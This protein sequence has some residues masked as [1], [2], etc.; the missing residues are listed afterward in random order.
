MRET[1]ELA[2][3]RR[4][5]VAAGHPQT[6]GAAVDILQAGGNAVDAVVAAT[7][8]A[9]VTEPVLASFGGGLLAVVEKDGARTVALDA[10]VQTP[11]QRRGDGLDFYPITGNFGTDTQEFHIGMASIATP[12]VPAGLDA[13]HA[14][15][16]SLPLERVVSPAVELATG[17]VELNADQHYTL[18]ILEPI[19]RANEH[20]ARLYGLAD[21]DAP[22]PQVG[23]RVYNREFGQLLT[24]LAAQGL[25]GF[26]RHQAGERLA[27]DSADGGGHLQREDLLGYRVYWREPLRWHYRDAAIASVPPPAIGGIMLSLASHALTERVG[28]GFEFGSDAHLSGLVDALRRA[29]DLR[30]RLEADNPNHE[31][32]GL[33]ATYES[34]LQTGRIASRGTTHLSVDDGRGLAVALTLSNGEGSGYILPGTGVMLNNML[35]EED[36]NRAGFH[37][38]PLDRRLA[39][40]MAPTIVRRGQARYLLGSGGSNRIRSALTQVI[41]NLVDCGLTLEQAVAAPRLHL[42]G[43]RLSVETPQAAWPEAAIRWLDRHAPAARRWPQRNLFFGGVNAVGPNAAVADPRRGGAAACAEP[44]DSS[45]V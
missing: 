38:W 33:R 32:D 6:T 3:R 14:R 43:E 31:E 20:T 34:L 15:F 11:R 45:G 25:D 18:R 21:R 37:V 8:T 22:L 23:A 39:S 27:R 7:L 10:F 24:E 29:S 28:G 19:V 30:T 42:E 26:Y 2:G 35:G 1:S 41:C 16:G 5:R 12:G 17:G 4:W 9:C 36:I 40:M 44:A 13:L